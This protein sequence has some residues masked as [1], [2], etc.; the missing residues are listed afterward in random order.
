MSLRPRNAERTAK[1]LEAATHLFAHQGYHGT[2]TR[3]IAD[4]AD[5]SENT[6]FR[7]FG[8]KEDVFWAALR[9]GLSGL[10]LLASRKGGGQC[11]FRYSQPARR[12]IFISVRGQISLSLITCFGHAAV[13]TSLR[14]PGGSRTV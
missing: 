4:L 10:H 9:E 13:V 14:A 6:L 1:I 7:L 2:T 5:M 12:H 3:E 11:A 8:G